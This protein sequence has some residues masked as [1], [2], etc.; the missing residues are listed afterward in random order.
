M[1]ITRKVDIERMLREIREGLSVNECHPVHG[2]R[3]SEPIKTIKVKL[4]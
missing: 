3:K 4:P 2:I 1:E